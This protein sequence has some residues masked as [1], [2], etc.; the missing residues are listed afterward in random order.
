MSV[1]KYNPLTFADSSELKKE[2]LIEQQKQINKLYSHS[3]NGIQKEIEKLSKKDNVSS[4]MKT[5][6]LEKLKKAMS[7][8]YKESNEKIKKAIESGVNTISNSVLQEAGKFMGQFGVDIEY[9]KLNKGITE[10]ILLGKVYQSDW[11]LSKAIWGDNQKTLE[12][13]NMIIAEGV[14]QNK[15]AYDIGKDL[16]QYVNPS[17]QK[18][19]NWSKVYPGTKKKIDYNAQ[20]LSRTLVNHAYQQATKESTRKN[21]FVQGLKWRSAMIHGRTCELCMERNGQIFKPDDVP[22]DHPNGL[23]TL[24]PV[25]DDLNDV[26]N[27]LADWVQGKSD[28][29]ID[30]YAKYLKGKN[31][32]IEGKGKDKNKTAETIKPKAKTK[33]KVKDTSTDKIK[34]INK[35]QQETWDN[36]YGSYTPDKLKNV[37]KILDEDI[38]S[39]PFSTALKDKKAYLEYLLENKNKT[40]VVKTATTSVKKKVKID[41]ESMSEK[42]LEKKALEIYKA[43]NSN[44]SVEQA[45][46]QFYGL[47]KGNSKN[48]IKDYVKKYNKVLDNVDDVSKKATDKVVRE[49]KVL[50]RVSKDRE[51]YRKD[52]KRRLRENSTDESKFNELFDTWNDKINDNE[53]EAVR[54]YTGSSY[55]EMNK[56]LRFGESIDSERL[57]LIK[58]CK[59]ALNKAKLPE[60]IVV[61][62]GSDYKALNGILGQSPD[63]RI[64]NIEEL[65]GRIATDKGFLS[66]TPIANAGFSGDVN[67][68]IELPK[69][70][71]AAYVAPIS[72]FRGEK[73]LLIQ[74]GTQ[75]II[76]A[77]EKEPTKLNIFMQAILK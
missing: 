20:R 14:A 26:S 53:R 65:V 51:E 22:L 18:D 74:S 71:K 5:Q 40:N 25:V 37:L 67:F 64:D 45:E 73:E 58:D 39:M 60:D 21:P 36:I 31:I 57:G 1:A 10:N 34:S 54:R 3:Y 17:A 41:I 6:E 42:Q 61:R 35:G 38:E 27:R 4:V 47:I 2:L 63:V 77:V 16:E 29:Q 19:W 7:K 43:K 44:L 23:C 15:S 11:T 24:V 55:S 13:I 76:K 62:R 52:I 75:Y 28:P 9:M 32:E 12:D 59:K 48:Q 46:K 69:G 50:D 68:I 66:T 30:E 72:N 8:A 49:N 70:T 33:T 56:H